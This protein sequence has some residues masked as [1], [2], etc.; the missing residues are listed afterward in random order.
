M[1]VNREEVNFI[2]L[3]MKYV[4]Y[5]HLVVKFLWYSCFPHQQIRPELS[6]VTSLYRTNDI[7]Y[8]SQNNTDDIY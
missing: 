2:Q 6:G 8:T 3:E 7:H 5:L 1:Y 4:S